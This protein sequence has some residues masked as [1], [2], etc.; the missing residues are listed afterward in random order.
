M[1]PGSLNTMMM[2]SGIP[3]DGLAAHWTMDNIVSTTLVDEQGSYDGTISA[4]PSFNA[5]VIGDAVDFNGNSGYLGSFGMTSV[6]LSAISMWIYITS[7]V[8]SASAFNLMGT[9][10]TLHG[11]F[12]TGSW[13]VVPTNETLSFSFHGPSVSDLKVYYIRD[14][15]AAGW[16]HVV[17]NWTGS[18][19][20]ISLGGAQKT[21]YTATN[22]SGYPA[23]Q[24]TLQYLQ[25]GKRFSVSQYTDYKFDQVRVY[26]RGS[27]GLYADEINAL[28]NEV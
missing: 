12:C 17:L 9:I 5:G 10:A 21:T 16:H 7:P 20:E 23:G 11:L 3:T 18:S 26:D 19:Y 8:T 6:T 2:G 25:F 24:V 15:I 1:I 13:S 4:S 22:G 14:N 27:A 28:Y